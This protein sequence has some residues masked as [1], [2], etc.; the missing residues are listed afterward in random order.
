MASHSEK[1]MAQ[2]KRDYDQISFV[3]DKDARYLI[4]AQA[5]REGVTSAEVIRRAVL[6]RC[7]LN[8]MP[9][10]TTQQ[11]QNLQSVE[12]HEEAEQALTRLQDDERD[13]EK[14]IFQTY[15]V[16]LTGRVAQ[17]EYIDGLLGLLD[18]IEDTQIPTKERGWQPADKLVIDKRKVSAIRRLLANLE[19]VESDDETQ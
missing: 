8:K 10:T 17:D 3:M 7:G 13:T 4:R 18:T 19:E 2:R 1:V 14:E 6:A 5:I 15:L 11:Y 12:L 9:D 16:T